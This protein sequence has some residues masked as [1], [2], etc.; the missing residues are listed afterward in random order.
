MNA[1]EML[2]QQH[3]E[4]EALFAQFKKAKSAGP[5]RKI[6]EQIADALA[7]HATIEEKR[8]YPSVKKKDTEE[9]LLESLEEHLEIKRVIA[10]LLALD[11]KDPTF[12]A[13]MT[14]LEEDVQHHVGEEEKD[15]FPKVEKLFDEETLEA[16]AEVMEETQDELLEDRNPREAIPSE[17]DTASGL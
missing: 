6:F 2:K 10:D 12:E 8:F 11:V 16:I 4:V 1:I 15:L 3:R 14:V 5:Q 13:K 7:V 17:T 9:L